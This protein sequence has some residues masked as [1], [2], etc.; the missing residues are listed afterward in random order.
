MAIESFIIKARR[1]FKLSLCDHHN[2]DYNRMVCVE[3]NHVKVNDIVEWIPYLNHAKVNDIVDW[4]PYQNHAKVNDIVDWIP[5]QNHA[6][7]I[8]IV[9]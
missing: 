1:T 6:K 3:I 7:V 9:D 5:Y 2:Q 8:D 4:I